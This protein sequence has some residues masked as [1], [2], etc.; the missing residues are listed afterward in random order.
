MVRVTFDSLAVN[1]RI[2]IITWTTA[3]SR[4]MIL[5]ITFRVDGAFVVQDAGI[6][7]LAVVAGTRVIAFAVR[8][9]VD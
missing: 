9:A 4:A 3:T 2:A 6:D 7:A 1:L 8:F 5:S